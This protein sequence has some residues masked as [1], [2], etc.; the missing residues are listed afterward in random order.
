MESPE[1][2]YYFNL[3]KDAAAAEDLYQTRTC[4]VTA[5]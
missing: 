4:H 1:W 5:K 3:D 2:Q